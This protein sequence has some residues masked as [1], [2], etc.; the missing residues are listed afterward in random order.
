MQVCAR[1]KDAFGKS[2][3][4]HFF[5]DSAMTTWAIDLPKQVRGG[6]HVLGNRSFAVAEG[7][8][9]MARSSVAAAKL[10]GAL[11]S[12]RRASKKQHPCVGAAA[13]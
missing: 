13:L 11:A 6:I 12:V 9:N 2:V 10:Q 3:P 4:P 7:A 8:Y 1:T 5:R